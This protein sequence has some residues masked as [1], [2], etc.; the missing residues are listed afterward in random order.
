L[1]GLVIPFAIFSQKR[2]KLGLLFYEG[3]LNDTAQNFFSFALFFLNL[4]V[5][6]AVIVVIL[7]DLF[8]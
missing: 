7:I 4:G 5:I 6:I 2:W 3:V 8:R 1:V